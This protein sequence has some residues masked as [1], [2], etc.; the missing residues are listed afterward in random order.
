[1]ETRCQ[2]SSSALKNFP[3]DLAT[4][5]LLISRR[6]KS[7]AVRALSA[8]PPPPRGSAARVRVNGG[9]F[10]LVVAMEGSQEWWGE[11]TFSQRRHFDPARATTM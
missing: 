3:E 11:A 4:L 2:T 10:Q 8:P 7:L 6:P 5:L 1:M 9:L